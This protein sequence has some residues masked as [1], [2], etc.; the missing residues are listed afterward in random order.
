MVQTASSI[1]CRK[2]GKQHPSTQEAAFEKQ[3]LPY[4]Y[5]AD[6]TTEDERNYGPPKV[7]LCSAAARVVI[8]AIP[9]N[10]V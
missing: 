8:M 1:G 9:C 10:S 4:L 2:A 3:Q 6:L 5:H 7:R